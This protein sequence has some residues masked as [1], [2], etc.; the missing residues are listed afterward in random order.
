MSGNGRQPNDAAE[1]ATDPDVVVYR[2]SG[3]FFFGTAASVAAA[4]DRI[5]K[6]PK[7]Y[8]IDFFAVP[9]LDSTGAAILLRKAEQRAAVYI[10]GAA[11]AGALKPGTSSCEM[12]QT[13]ASA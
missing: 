6:H 11:R 5:G 8:V 1:L 10:A 4:L 7:A 3:A 13:R 12:G 9:V 2:I